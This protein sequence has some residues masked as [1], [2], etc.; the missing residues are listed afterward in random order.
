VGGQ[1][2]QGGVTVAVQGGV[3]RPLLKR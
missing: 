1:S 3:L 2:S